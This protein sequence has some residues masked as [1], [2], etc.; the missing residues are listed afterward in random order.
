[1]KTIGI[2]ASAVLVVTLIGAAI[3]P[4][5]T[6]AA[7]APVGKSQVT[8]TRD[9][10]PIV[11]KDCATCHHAGEVAPFPLVTY[12]DVAKRAQQ[13]AIVTQA[14]Y[15]PPWK[16]A[17]DCPSFKDERRLTAAEIALI[18]KWSEEGALEGSPKDL[19]PAP[20]FATSWKLGSPDIVLQPKG[21]YHL[22]ADG[23]DVYRCFVI[24]TSY[25][26]DRYLSA[27]EVRPGNR[28]V[29]H[30]VIAYLDTNG[31]ARQL[32]GNDPAGGYT[33]FGGPG[34]P[35]TGSL[36]GWAPGMDPIQMPSDTGILLP[37]GADIVLQ[38]HYHKDGKPED[39][40]TRIGLYFAK[41]SVDKQ[42]DIAAAI[43]P[44]IR[45]PAGDNSYAANATLP[46]LTN[47]TVLGVMPHMHLLGHDMTVTAS[48]PDGAKQT[49]VHVPD[50]D[51]NWQTIYMY[52]H[53]LHLPKGASIDLVAHYDNSE[54]NA[55]NPNIPPKLV[56]WGEQTTDEMCIAFVFFTV[57]AEHLTK[58]DP[59]KMAPELERHT[60]LVQFILRFD[61][62]GDGKLNQDELAA[63]LTYFRGQSSS[64]TGGAGIDQEQ[65]AGKVI[66][67]FDTDHDGK[68]DPDELGQAIA[69]LRRFR[70]QNAAQK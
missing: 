37:K 69:F 8:F 17:T 39:D 16:A 48:L 49:L 20:H 25:T 45:I 14:R 38:V 27:V 10:A 2:L 40:L 9:I 61:K 26:R 7:T 67:M 60:L 4:D 6:R 23:D 57:D 43:D 52:K 24:P 64:Q 62:D 15:M 70:S 33:S 42:L 53:P 34:F 3:V 31:K 21:E 19:P 54:G 11:Y 13:I 41:G 66:P 59:V 51:F 65:V 22:A 44:L 5:T 29:V 35:A 36:G 56:T 18:Q 50:W 68:L 58:G 46:V 47:I 1:M 32:A 12:H 28:R 55:R 63:M 30:H